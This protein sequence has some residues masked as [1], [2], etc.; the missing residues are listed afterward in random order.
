MQKSTDWQVPTVNLQQYLSIFKCQL[1]TANFQ[2][3]FF[4]CQLFLFSIKS[5]MVIVNRPGVAGVVLQTPP[6]RI[7]SLT[8]QYFSSQSSKHNNSQTVRARDLKV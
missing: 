8:Q 5:L 2:M 3:K 1:S 6:S 7:N 4:T